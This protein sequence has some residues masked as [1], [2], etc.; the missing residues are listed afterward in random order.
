VGLTVNF[1]GASQNGTINHAPQNERDSGSGEHNEQLLQALWGIDL[2]QRVQQR[3]TLAEDHRSDIVA[4]CCCF[5]LN[6]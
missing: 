4:V 3:Q 2:R 5:Y 6:L 1:I